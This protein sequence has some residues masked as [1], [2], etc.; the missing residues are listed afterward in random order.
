[1]LIRPIKISDLKTVEELISNTIT[2]I[3][4]K[5]YHREIIDF[6]LKVDPFRPRNTKNEREYFICVDNNG[7][8]GIIWA[9]EN[10]IKTFF[11]NTL[12]QGKWIGTVLLLYIEKH[13]NN[14]GFNNIKVYS[15]LSAKSFYENNGYKI[16]KKDISKI[17]K[18]A[19]IRYHMEKDI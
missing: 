5:D 13:I 1:M 10:E 6:M 18:E 19:M 14:K 8:Y 3:N 17:N 12:F 9:K 11:V 15:S 2:T 4:S 7:I 16:I